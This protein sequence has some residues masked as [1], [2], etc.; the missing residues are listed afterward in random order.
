MDATK[1]ASGG[2]E[3]WGIWYWKLEERKS[4]LHTGREL[5][6]LAEEIAKVKCQKCQP[7]FSLLLIIKCEDKDKLKKLLNMEPE[8]EDSEIS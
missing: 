6:Y 7:G 1:G 8:S 2:V 3:K 4:L 5:G